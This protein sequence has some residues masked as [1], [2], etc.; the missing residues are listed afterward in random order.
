[1]DL[2]RVRI[3]RLRTNSFGDAQLY[4]TTG[5]RRFERVRFNLEGTSARGPKA[6]LL[7]AVDRHPF[8]P[9]VSAELNDRCQE[10]FLTQV[11]GLAKRLE[12]TGLPRPGT[13]ATIGVSGGLDSTLALLVACK[14]F[15]ALKLAA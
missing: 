8:V 11:T 9:R 1:I 2:E 7:R 6:G 10:I 13:P 4:L 15:H 14:T 3:D 12:H 5:A